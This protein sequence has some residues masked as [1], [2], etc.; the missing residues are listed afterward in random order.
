[1]PGK[2]NLMAVYSLGDFS[3]EGQGIPSPLSLG[4]LFPYKKFK[5][6]T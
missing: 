2:S 4:Y 6:Q 1:V 5:I 3:E